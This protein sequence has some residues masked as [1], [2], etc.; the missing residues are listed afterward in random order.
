MCGDVPDSYFVIVRSLSAQENNLLAVRAELRKVGIG[1]GV[2]EQ[3]HRSGG[4]HVD[5]EGIA[6][7]YECLAIRAVGNRP[8]TAHRASPY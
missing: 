2:I 6:A 3:F 4:G 7:E 8:E 1:I 5:A